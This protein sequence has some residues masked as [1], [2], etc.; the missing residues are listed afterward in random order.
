[1]LIGLGAKSAVGMASISGNG[2]LVI[3]REHVPRLFLV[4]PRERIME[5]MPRE[6][7]KE[8]VPRKRKI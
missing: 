3:S 7:I 5:A 1:V 8:V 6:R 2:N 4:D